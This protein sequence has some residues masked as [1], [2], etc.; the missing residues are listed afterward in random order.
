MTIFC[1]HENKRWKKIGLILSQATAIEIAA[2]DSG[3]V[4]V[5]ASWHACNNNCPIFVNK[6][7]NAK[8]PLLNRPREI[9]RYILK[10]EIW[11]LGGSFYLDDNNSSMS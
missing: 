1:K 6:L 10:F 3:G 4:S 8:C 2:A 7:P 9:A 11:L 5:H